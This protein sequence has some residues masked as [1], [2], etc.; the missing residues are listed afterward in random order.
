MD[1]VREHGPT[2]LTFA[3]LSARVGLAPATLVQRF[4]TKAQLLHAALSRAWDLLEAETV[5]ADVAAA[6]DASGAVD[7]LVQLSGT[8]EQR[9]YPDQ[10]LV[11]R[12][13][14][15]DPVLRRRGEAW[16]ASVT[17]ALDRR[18]GGDAAGLGPLL[19]AQ[20]Q[21]T[22]AVN[23][24]RPETSLTSAVRGNL[25]DLLRRVGADRQGSA[26]TRARRGGGRLVE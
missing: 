3:A 21:G 6:L 20:W 15:R 16:L 12:E 24:F 1:V 23:A 17:E 14:L 18:L 2:A 5:A 11:P 13:D 7:L 22:L 26:P 25:D 10:L 9:D 8:H 19:L 4:G